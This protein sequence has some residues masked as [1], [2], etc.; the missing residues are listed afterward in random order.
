ML[1]RLERKINNKDGFIELET[2]EIGGLEYAFYLNH[3]K[4]TEKFLYTTKAS[5]CF[6]I[7][8]I[9]G[10]YRAVFFYKDGNNISIFKID[11]YIDSNQKLVEAVY[12]KIVEKDGYKI[13]FY[14]IGATKT[15]VVF[16]GA[17]STKKTHPFGLYYLVKNGFNV[18]ACLQENNQY[19]DLSF[20][21][22]EKY[23]GPIVNEHDVYLYGSSLGGYCAVYYAGAL[24]GTVIA[25]APR[26]SSHP[27]LRDK[28]KDTSYFITQQFKH[29][30]FNQN[31][32][33]DKKIFIF[34]DPYVDNDIY[35]LNEV[36]KKELKNIK[37]F[38]CNYAGHEVFF[39]L[40][41]TSQLKEI[42]KSITSGKDPIV[43]DIDSCYSYIGI[44]KDYLKKKDYQGALFFSERALVDKSI[45]K[46]FRKRFE[47][48]NSI[49]FKAY[50]KN[51][52]AV[53]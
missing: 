40:K 3:S 24:N 27:S 15:F 10:N 4:G 11:F 8:F 42:I 23:V 19:Q 39:H 2:A 51:K 20:E 48:V 12:R 41:S 28:V 34:I 31:K 7:K 21:D 49:A 14:N 43:Y 47:K 36:I 46:E 37:Q 45:N 38:N 6:N 5:N 30:R 22:V 17:G 9:Q 35:F 18:V 50:Q 33:S 29:V 32:N 53:T 26:N 16:N 52:E 13:D 1:E 25:S 44:A